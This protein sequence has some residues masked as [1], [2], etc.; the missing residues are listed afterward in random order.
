M[1]EAEQAVRLAQPALAIA[2]D[3]PLSNVNLAARAN[4]LTG[5]RVG[6]SSEFVITDAALRSIGRLRGRVV[7]IRVKGQE[8]RNVGFDDQAAGAGPAR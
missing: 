7:V 8:F 3:P 5:E 4:V 2:F 1:S 6:D